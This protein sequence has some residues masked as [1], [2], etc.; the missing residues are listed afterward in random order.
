MHLIQGTF[1]HGALARMMLARHKPTA[2]NS[3]RMISLLVP[4]IKA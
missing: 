3:E 1:E 4:A 2:D